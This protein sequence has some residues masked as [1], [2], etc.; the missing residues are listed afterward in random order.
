MA[1]KILMSFLGRVSPD[2]NGTYKRVSYEIEGEV[3]NPSA[4]FAIALEE[5]L[6]PDK[7]VI[8][9][10]PTSG[11]DMLIDDALLE[12]VQ[13]DET[14]IYSEL[15][16]I[17]RKAKVGPLAQADLDELTNLLTKAF[18][19]EF[20]LRIIPNGFDELEQLQLLKLMANEV[21]LRDRVHIDVT[22][23]FRHLPMLALTSALHLQSVKDAS[24]DG[25][26][27][28][29]FQ[30][31]QFP[32]KA[33]KLTGLLTIADGVR[34]LAMFDK[35]GDYTSLS[36]LFEKSEP[37]GSNLSELLK[38]AAFYEN[39]LNF[40][41]ARAQI[42]KLNSAIAQH[43]N[44][45]SVELQL[46]I[47]EI[48]RRT[49]WAESPDVVD[50]MTKIVRRSLNNGD[51]L[52]AALVLFEA[53]ITSACEDRGVSVSNFESRKIVQGELEE[54]LVETR[55]T[56]LPYYSELKSIRNSLAH[57]NE[58]PSSNVARILG[59]RVSL[60]KNLSET[61]SLFAARRFKVDRSAR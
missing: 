60:G 42:L 56:A 37:A 5:R 46:I 3:S 30:G 19:V 8:F 54:Y 50:R 35:D 7:T 12:R 2:E 31:S 17:Q 23:G 48:E 20:L 59:D 6:R 13:G 32:A 9:G 38:T 1:K 51:Y 44:N 26:W 34:A 43:R 4:L 18:S 33:V 53:I 52:R 40:N 55:S 41:G 49:S 14:E 16:L 45:L 57:G 58:A 15:E 28:S 21:G 11:W 36:K 24:I 29:V 10:T 39:T 25:L 47:P 22:H 61:L 27:Y